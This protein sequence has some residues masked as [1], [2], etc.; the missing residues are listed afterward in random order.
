MPCPF[1]LPCRCLDPGAWVHPPRLPLGDPHAGACHAGPALPHEPPEAHQRELCNYGYARYRCSHFPDDAAAD[2][3]RFS[4]A[5]EAGGRLELIYVIEKDHAPVEHGRLIR[6]IEEGR[7]ESLHT[8]ELLARQAQAFVES[9][10]RRA[11]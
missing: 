11:G 2:A 3:V 5:S 4:I 7:W 10:L 9:H 6:L 1:F 8:S